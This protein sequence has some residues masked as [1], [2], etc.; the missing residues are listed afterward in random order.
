M[1][2]VAGYTLLVG[3]GGSVVRSAIMGSLALTAR[4]IGRRAHGLNAL[5]FQRRSWVC[6]RGA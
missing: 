2:G 6:S 1:L 5:A 4:K 3:A